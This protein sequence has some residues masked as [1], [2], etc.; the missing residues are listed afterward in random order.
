MV[1]N[2]IYRY[3]LLKNHIDFLISNLN[4]SRDFFKNIFFVFFFYFHTIPN[5]ELSFMFSIFDSLSFEGK[6]THMRYF[7]YFFA[8]HESTEP[9]IANAF[10]RWRKERAY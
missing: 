4:T 8:G 5:L 1:I 9:K 7:G 10:S 6:R 3:T 2:R